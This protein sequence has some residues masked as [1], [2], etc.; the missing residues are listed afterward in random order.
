MKLYLQLSGSEKNEREQVVAFLLE[1]ND[2]EFKK[3]LNLKQ[4]VCSYADLVSLILN[5]GNVYVGLMGAIWKTR[6]VK[7]FSAFVDYHDSHDGYSDRWRSA[8]IEFKMYDKKSPK[9]FWFNP[10]KELIKENDLNTFI[11]W[12]KANENVWKRVWGF[13]DEG[14]NCLERYK[15][16][17]WFDSWVLAAWVIVGWATKEEAQEVMDEFKKPRAI[18]S[19]AKAPHPE[20]MN[21]IENYQLKNSFNPL[22]TAKMNSKC[23]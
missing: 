18:R 4:T 1:D 15:M 23:L 3:W 17:E 5:V 19:I 8:Y 6:A 13:Y 10:E 12:M 22:N 14:K 7:C 21:V 2:V 20:T 11:L 9:T 16:A